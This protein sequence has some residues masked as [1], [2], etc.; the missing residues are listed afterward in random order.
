MTEFESRLLG[1]LF[2]IEQRLSQIAALM[3]KDAYPYNDP[4]EDP[5]PR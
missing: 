4:S 1:V 5:G 2:E 3:D